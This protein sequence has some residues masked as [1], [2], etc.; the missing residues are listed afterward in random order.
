VQIVLFIRH[1]QAEFKAGH[2]YGW[3][4][5][6]HLSAHGRDEVKKLAELLEP[7]KLNAIYSSPLERCSETAE[8][9]RDGRKL[10]IQTIEELG[11][12]RYGSWQG[13]AYKNLVKTPL[14]RVIQT[15]PS[16]ATFPGGE[17]LLE[18]Q[19]R[20]VQA[21]ETI[22]D[23]HRRGV[24]A[25]VSH[26][27]MIKAILTHYLGMHLD[28]FQRIVV[29]TASVSAVA[30]WGQGIPRLIRL[31]EKGTLGDLKLPPVRRKAKKT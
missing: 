10:E 26:A 23:K 22:R 5:G 13:K 24:I 1:G 15:V 2:L 7:V 28:L 25:V 12:V 17:S 16:Q 8:A 11:E 18:L 20:G 27:D 31:N 14:W 6:V 3:T 30:F 21:V 9:V 19:R 4:P 29:D